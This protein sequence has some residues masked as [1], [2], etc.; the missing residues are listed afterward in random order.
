[1]KKW[2]LLIAPALIA[3]FAATA[4]GIV[5]AGA[6]EPGNCGEYMYWKGGKCVDAR[7]RQ[8]GAWSDTMAAK[9][10]TW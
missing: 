8:A 9:K 4:A 3:A 1:M 7:D 10:A 6:A 5:G 2:T